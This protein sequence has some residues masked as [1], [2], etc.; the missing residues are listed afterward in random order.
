M[1]S[2]NIS[3]L[4]YGPS[5]PTKV[6]VMMDAVLTT[7]GVHTSLSIHLSYQWIINDLLYL[8]LTLSHTND[9]N[10]KCT[11]THTSERCKVEDFL[12]HTQGRE[13]SLASLSLHLLLTDCRET[14]SCLTCLTCI[15]V[16]QIRAP[17]QGTSF[18]SLMSLEF[19]LSELY[20]TGLS[21]RLS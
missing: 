14:I 20:L 8:P 6:C 17:W 3:R 15:F 12:S 4:F 7:N 2:W 19:K 1:F 21:D 13:P 16:I 5:L 11:G 18:F 9:S 10:Y